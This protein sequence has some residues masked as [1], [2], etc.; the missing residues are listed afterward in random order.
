MGNSGAKSSGP[1]GS[2][3]P[4]WRAGGG[5]DGRSGTMLYQA[6]GISLSSSRYLCWWTV[7]SM[8]IGYLLVAGWC[9]KIARSCTVR[10]PVPGRARLR[11]RSGK[12]VRW[13]HGSAASS[14]EATRI[15]WASRKAPATIWTPTGSP[16]G[17][18][19]SGRLTAG[20]PVMLNRAVKA[21]IDMISMGGK[22]GWAW[23]WASKPTGGG[24]MAIVGVTSRSNSSSNRA[25]RPRVMQLERHQR[26]GEVKTVEGPGRRNETRLWGS[27][28]AGS[29]SRWRAEPGVHQ[30]EEV[31][32]VA[33]VEQVGVEAGDLV[34]E[35]L[36][37][38]GR[39]VHGGDGL[40]VP[41]RPRAQRRC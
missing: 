36:E 8:A 20:W 34:A 21:A 3:V 35:R 40:R 6:V 11:R 29:M 14:W 18:T 5:G 13:I 23:T 9:L 16:D 2:R 27:M 19:C 15:S 32:E 39:V 22:S 38:R 33:R 25:S 26:T 31:A 28:S 7:S 41:P 24:S 10:A 12:P 37:Q 30:V 4:G 17:E 1:A